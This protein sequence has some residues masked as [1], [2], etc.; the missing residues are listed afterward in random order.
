MSTKIFLSAVVFVV[1][2]SFLFLL[3]GGGYAAALVADHHAVGLFELIPTSV[4]EQ[5]KSEFHIWYMHTSHG[6]QI[7]SGMESLEDSNSIYSFNN[8]AGSVIIEEYSDDLGHN[9]DTSWVPIT[10]QRLDA[11]DGDS[12]NIVMWS[13]CGGVSDNS[14]EGINTYLHAVS[15]LEQDYPNV[16]FIY[17]T[18]H[19]D[20]SGPTGNLYIRNNQIRAYCD[21]TDKVLFDFADIESYDPDGNYY[22]DASDACE[23]CVTWCSSNPCPPCAPIRGCSHSNCFNCF[24]KGKAFWWLLASLTGWSSGMDV[25]SDT[26]GL[27]AGSFTLKQNYPNP[28]NPVTEISFTLPVASHTRLDIYNIMGQKVVTLVD[29]RL[30]AGDHTVKWNGLDEK[31]E[32]VASGI[33]LYHLQADDFTA[34]KKMVL[35]K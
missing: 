6:S 16:T 26:E 25:D 31:G 1:A 2:F 18:G 15:Q 13:W 7:L 11:P 22:P 3:P 34:S 9:G 33:Y 20:G 17:M 29:R 21:S 27:L 35:L 5:V 24:N 32:P 14:E 4:I 12:I 30:S 8:G 28:F 23:W 10:R 19:L